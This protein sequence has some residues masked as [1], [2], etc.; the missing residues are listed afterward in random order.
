MKKPRDWPL[1]WDSTI[2]AWDVR[3]ELIVTEAWVQQKKLVGVPADEIRD[4]IEEEVTH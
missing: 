2:G 4:R 3:K 1:K